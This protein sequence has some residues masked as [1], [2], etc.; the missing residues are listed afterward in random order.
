M[1]H[2]LL[3]WLTTFCVLSSVGAVKQVGTISLYDTSL[4]RPAGITDPMAAS[5]YMLEEG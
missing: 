2:R 1:A 4:P 3:K 5:E